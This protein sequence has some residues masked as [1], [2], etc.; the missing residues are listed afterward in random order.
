MKAKKSGKKELSPR[1]VRE[2]IGYSAL[3]SERFTAETKGNKIT[4]EGRGF[5]HG[6]GMCQ[7]G[8]RG[9]ALEGKDHAEYL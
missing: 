7:W 4:S 9:M 5:G 8:A 1:S 3:Y 2:A 6:V